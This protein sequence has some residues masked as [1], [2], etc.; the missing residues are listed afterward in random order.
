M[1]RPNVYEIQRQKELYPK[2]HEALIARSLHV[3][4]R[5]MERFGINIGLGTYMKITELCGRQVAALLKDKP[6]FRFKPSRR[7]K[8]FSKVNPKYAIEIILE[9]TKMMAV[10]DAY[11]M[12]LLTVFFH[13][14][15]DPHPQVIYTGIS[16]HMDKFYEKAK[17]A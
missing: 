15:F 11:D 6:E 16:I 10:Y 13:G 17:E 9:G 1:V 5:M 3:R 12:M 4:T 7:Y 2:H 8:L 14:T